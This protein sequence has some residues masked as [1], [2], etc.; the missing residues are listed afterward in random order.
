MEV[1]VQTTNFLIEK[2]VDSNE[3]FWHENSNATFSIGI[4]ERIKEIFFH[5]FMNDNIP[6]RFS[7]NCYLQQKHT[8]RCAH[9]RRFQN[10]KVEKGMEKSDGLA[11]F[12]CVTL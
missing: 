6:L 4:Q 7:L 2:N 9:L 11:R 3:R 10:T 8:A 5:S 1:E 12:L